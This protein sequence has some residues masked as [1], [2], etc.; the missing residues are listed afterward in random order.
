MEKIGVVEFFCILY[1]ETRMENF[2][3]MI[4]NAENGRM[5]AIMIS[6]LDK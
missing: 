2:I 3:G 4:L 6:R 5:L 1:M